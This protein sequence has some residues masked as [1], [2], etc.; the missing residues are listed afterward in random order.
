MI[1]AEQ[2][3]TEASIC[4]TTTWFTVVL[5]VIYQ[6]FVLKEETQN[7]MDLGNVLQRNIFWSML[8]ISSDYE[9]WNVIMLINLAVMS[10]NLLMLLKLFTPV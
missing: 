10:A 2:K 9:A 5:L 4:K 3:C 8:L 7:L 6:E 1:Q